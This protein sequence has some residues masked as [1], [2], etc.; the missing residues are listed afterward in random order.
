MH[1]VFTPEEMRQFETCVRPRMEAGGGASANA[2]AYL[3]AT[4]E[5]DHA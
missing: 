5:P 4:K 1:Q 2:L 3:R